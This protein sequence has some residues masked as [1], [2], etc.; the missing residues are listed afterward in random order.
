VGDLAGH[1]APAA[2][3]RPRC[4]CLRMTPCPRPYNE[5]SSPNA[6]HVIDQASLWLHTVANALTVM[7]RTPSEKVPRYVCHA[8]TLRN[9]IHSGGSDE[10][11][12][13]GPPVSTEPTP[14]RRR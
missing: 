13:S 12:S 2:V 7:I 14:W 3:M 5:M 6:A 9:R 11:E 10:G 1:E 8:Q 4:A